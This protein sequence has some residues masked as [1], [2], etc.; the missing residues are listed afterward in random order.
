MTENGLCNLQCSS[1]QVVLAG[2]AVTASL[3]EVPLEGNLGFPLHIWV[4][5]SEVLEAKNR[6]SD[7]VQ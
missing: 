1:Y 7:A 6:I 5:I 4:Y 3:E 2:C